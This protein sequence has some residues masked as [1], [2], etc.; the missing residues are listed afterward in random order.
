MQTVIQ[1]LW[2]GSAFATPNDNQ[3]NTKE[4]QSPI[5]KNKLTVSEFNSG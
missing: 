2:L 3:K 5:M 4:A 1:P